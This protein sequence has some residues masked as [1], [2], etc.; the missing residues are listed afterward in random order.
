M[1]EKTYTLRALTAD[2]MFPMFNI[3]SGIG[4]KE[5]KGVFENEAVQEAIRKA[6]NAEGE[7]NDTDVSALGVM[8]AFDV[9]SVI[10]GNIPKCK[11]DIY[12]FLSG[13]SGM[14]KKEIAGLP[15]NTFFNMI[16]DVIKKE[17]FK[18][19]FQAVSRLFK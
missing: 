7:D 4:I 15:M 17:E 3:I 19:F 16:V 1:D 13:L 14:T 8:I 9:A 2:D 12:Q 10:F 11:D 5:F 6:T 18:D